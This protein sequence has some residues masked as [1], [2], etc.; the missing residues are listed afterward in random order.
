MLSIIIP[1]RN[2]I[3]N[4]E[5]IKEEFNKKLVNIK[6]EVIF[7]N[8]FSTDRTF[9][10]AKEIAQLNINFKVFDNKKKGLGGAINFGIEKSTG[11]YICIMMADLSDDFEDLKNY[12]TKIKE[13]NLDAVF[14][15]RFS[16]ESKV[17]DYPLKKLILNR[18][19]NFIVQVLFLNKY[20]DYTNAFKIYN[21]KVLKS[22]LPFVSESFNIF[23]E[24]PLKIISRKYSY[25]IV[26][27]NWY[28]RKKG[29]AKF[30]IKELRSKYL[31]T[32]IYCFIGKVL[33]N[34]KIK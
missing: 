2:E 34:K 5:N 14:G 29:K 23:L 30:N 13:N 18:I 4:L 28:N 20:N 22:M 19:F 9:Q 27:I 7:V 31:F 24:I 1:L 11:N 26:P 17:E 3:D 32:L 12:Y 10:K 8:D 6:F 21:S 33:L 15:S 25:S 16:K